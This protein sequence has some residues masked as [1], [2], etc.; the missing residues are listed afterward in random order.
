MSEGEMAYAWTL[1]ES[2]KKYFEDAFLH[3]VP[4]KLNAFNSEELDKRMI[5]V[6]NE[7]EFVFVRFF[8]TYSMY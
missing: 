3:K 5:T 1:Y 8:R 2:K 4:S 7:K 6:P